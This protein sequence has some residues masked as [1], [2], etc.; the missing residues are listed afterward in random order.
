VGETRFT[1]TPEAMLEGD[2]DIEAALARMP[3]SMRTK[4]MFFTRLVELLGGAWGEVTKTLEGPP[5]LGRY[6]PFGDYSA[7]DHLR[8]IDAAARRAM[9]EVPTREAH[10]RLGQAVIRMFADSTL[11]GVIVKLV[12]EDV[13]QALLK[14]PEAYGM[15]VK[16]STSIRAEVLSDDSVRVTWAERPPGLEYVIGSL[17]G[18][19]RHFKREPMVDVILGEV[20]AVFEVR[21]R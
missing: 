11:G 17:E 15:V 18:I 3:E 19:V 20:E 6:I 10:R 1:T 5:R 16:G 13:Q 4:G 14:Y 12:N 9:P 7:R 8:V 2:V 21:W